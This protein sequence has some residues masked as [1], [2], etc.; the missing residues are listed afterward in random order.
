VKNSPQVLPGN[1]GESQPL[2]EGENEE[3][4][5]NGEQSSP[6]PADQTSCTKAFLGTINLSD[7]QEF[8]SGD[9]I[10]VIFTLENTGTCTWNS[11]YSLIKIGGD[12]TPSSGKLTI[13]GEVVTGES[14]DL[15]VE[16][17]ATSQVG[18][19]LSV[20]KMEYPEGGV[21]GQK[22]PP[23]AGENNHPPDSSWQSS[24]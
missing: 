7:G 21:F 19:Y 6:P 15:S 10:Q 11:G 1:A 23:N 12:L 18:S 4:S 13:P 16:F 8:E 2:P 5:S 22:G 17:I 20:W 3:N 9:S 14:V 24:A